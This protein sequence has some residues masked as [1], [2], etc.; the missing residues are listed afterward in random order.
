MKQTREL[1][2]GKS[3]LEII[4]LIWI[5]FVSATWVILNTYEKIGNSG[6]VPECVKKQITQAGE[7][8][9]KYVWRQYRYAE[10]SK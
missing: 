5:T 4:L 2:W 7:N 3:I 9:Y 10:Q 6:T 1:S 8:I